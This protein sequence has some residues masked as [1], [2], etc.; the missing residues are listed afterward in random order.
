M[1][2]GKVTKELLKKLMAARKAGSTYSQ[3]EN[4]FGVS[5][6]TTIRYLKGVEP[7][8]APSGNWKAAEQEAANELDKRGFKIILNL[9]EVCPFPFWDYYVVKDEDKWLIDVTVNKYKSVVDKSHRMVTGYRCA[10]LYKNGSEWELM[11]IKT[12]KVW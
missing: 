6:W 4:E 3:I 1:R 11:E 9:N 12:S 2:K 10:V 7:R 5:R 8:I